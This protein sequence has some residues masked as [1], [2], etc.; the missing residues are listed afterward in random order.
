[1]QLKARSLSFSLDRPFPRPLHHIPES[2]LLTDDNFLAMK[3]IQDVHRYAISCYHRFDLSFGHA[4]TDAHEDASFLIMTAL[5]LSPLT[6]IKEW[7]PAQLTKA[8]KIVLLDL[9]KKRCIERIPTA[10][11]LQSAYQQGELFYIDSRALIPRSYIGEILSDLSRAKALKLQAETPK[12]ELDY[13]D[14]FGVPDSSTYQLQPS[15]KVSLTPISQQELFFDP[16]NIKSVLDLC[17]GSGCLAILASKYLPHVR[18]IDAIDISSD[19]LEV[20]KVNVERSV[21]GE[22]V[23]LFEGNLFHALSSSAAEEKGSKP[24]QYDLIISNPPYVTTEAMVELPAEY[25]HEPHMALHAYD[26]LLIVEQILEQAADY[27]SDTG[28]LL[29]EVGFAG[30]L[31]RD[32]YASAMNDVVW[33]STVNS[34]GEVF[35]AN[36][37]ALLALQSAIRQK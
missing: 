19:A 5:S 37:S 35:Y 9:L 24:P 20:A 29:C 25:I 17:T 28:G 10:Y 21:Y 36:K 12:M 34:D 31:L 14:Y 7:Y 26:G 18:I 16:D 8:E 13:E 22:K 1:M 6:S 23:R 15:N 33:V 27:V 30:A 4:T 2:N 11:L 32:K 3:S